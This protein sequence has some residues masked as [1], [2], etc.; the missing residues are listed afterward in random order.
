M[1]QSINDN[2]EDNMEMI[3]KNVIENLKIKPKDEFLLKLATN[4]MNL[5]IN[6]FIIETNTNIEKLYIDEF[7]NSIENDEMILLTDKIMRWL[8]DAED[9]QNVRNN[10][11]ICIENNKIQYKK[12]KYNNINEPFVITK[13]L[14][15][16]NNEVKNLKKRTFISLT[17]EDFKI[18]CMA[19]NTEKSKKIRDYYIA[20]DDIFKKYVFYQKICDKIKISINENIIKQ[21]ELEYKNMVDENNEKDIKIKSLEVANKTTLQLV[22]NLR[23][24]HEKVK[25]HI[26]IITDDNMR[27]LNEW[28]QMTLSFV[29]LT[30]PHEVLWHTNSVLQQFH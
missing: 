19:I 10:I 23:R 4:K 22:L 24:Y 5:S 18:L 6:D 1:S 2:K 9:I 27:L 30:K 21:K 26:Y 17:G 12:L 11:K 20:I 13:G 25:G 15:F 3:I 28:T 16:E 8:S 14:N 29:K 7:W